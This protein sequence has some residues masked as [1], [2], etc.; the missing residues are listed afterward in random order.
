MAACLPAVSQPGEV[1][2]WFGLAHVNLSRVIQGT[3][4]VCLYEGVVCL[5]DKVPHTHLT[6][7]MPLLRAVIVLQRSC[8]VCI[9]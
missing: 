3:G 9:K 6:S 7:R 8:G 2:G 5:C 1:E 4:S